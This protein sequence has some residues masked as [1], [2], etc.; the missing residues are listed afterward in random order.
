[1]INKEKINPA[2]LDLACDFMYNYT[3]LKRRI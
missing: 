1:M 3:E 2:I